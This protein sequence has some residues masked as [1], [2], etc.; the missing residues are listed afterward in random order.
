M[1]SG[2]ALDNFRGFDKPESNWFKMPNNWTDI[3]AEI[4]SLAEMKVVEYTIR[5]TWG[6]Q[7]FGVLKKI[8]IDEYMNGRKRKDGTRIDSGT[9]LSKPSVID[10]LKRAI[11][12]GLLIETIDDSDRARIRK[13]YAPAM[14]PKQDCKDPD[15]DVKKLYPDVKELDSG[16]KETLHRS[17]KE[18]SEINLKKEGA[19]APT[20]S[21]EFQGKDYLE[22]A[23][24]TESRQKQT[25]EPILETAGEIAKLL[26][27][28][29]TDFQY[30]KR[31]SGPISEMVRHPR[32][33][34]DLSALLTFI[35]RMNN[36]HAY[37]FLFEQGANSAKGLVGEVM[38]AATSGIRKKQSTSAQGV[39]DL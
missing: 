5:H 18:T 22:L 32:F 33:D 19:S 31:W 36:S 39:Y 35:Q 1:T 11:D 12:H 15:G 38:K 14:K 26:G 27:T 23:A 13:Y 16:G 2:K 29:V 6:F 7:E 3:T 17:E 20:H 30:E 28:T 4:T 34:G 37:D 10:G 21:S 25:T 8:T 24:F 9:G